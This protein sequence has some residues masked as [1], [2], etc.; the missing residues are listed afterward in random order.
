MKPS[1]RIHALAS[2][3]LADVE[4]RAEPANFEVHRLEYANASLARAIVQY[5]DQAN[6]QQCMFESCWRAFCVVMAM[7]IVRANGSTEL[8]RQYIERAGLQGLMVFDGNRIDEVV[9][10]IEDEAREAGIL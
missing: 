1:E 6:S 4:R 7:G 8:A 10:S 5:L 3:L 2:E 9:S